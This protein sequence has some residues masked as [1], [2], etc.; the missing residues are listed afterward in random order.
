MRHLE[1]RI[2]IA[3]RLDVIEQPDHTDPTTPPRHRKRV[4]H[5]AVADDIQY[6]MLRRQAAAAASSITFATAPDLDTSGA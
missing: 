5:R 4:E 1:D 3:D 2:E 6:G